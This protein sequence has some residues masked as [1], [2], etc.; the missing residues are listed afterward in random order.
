M[1]SVALCAWCVIEA[2]IFFYNECNSCMNFGSANNVIRRE[3]RISC[4]EKK[5]AEEAKGTAI[6]TVQIK[7][8]ICVE[9][10]RVGS[11]VNH[12]QRLVK[13]RPKSY[14][15]TLCDEILKFLGRRLQ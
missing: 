5:Q 1:P 6:R 3:S 11:T 4:F 13:G 2:Q 7:C 10:P 9:V 8:F 14:K 15:N 12:M